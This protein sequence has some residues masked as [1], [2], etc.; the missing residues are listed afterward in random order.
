MLYAL[1]NLII[2]TQ[3]GLIR[4]GQINPVFV[5]PVSNFLDISY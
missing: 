5:A 4:N 3:M 1:G 2:Q